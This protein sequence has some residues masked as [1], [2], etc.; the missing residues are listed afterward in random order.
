MIISRSSSA[1]SS[2]ISL[3]PAGSRRV[4]SLLRLCVCRS[5][6]QYAHSV[7]AGGVG[8]LREQ[9]LRVRPADN[10]GDAVRRQDRLDHRAAR[11]IGAVAGQLPIGIGGS[12]RQGPESVCRLIETGLGKR[13]MMRPTIC[14]NASKYGVSS[15]LPGL[16]IVTL[17]RSMSWMR[18]P[19]GVSSI[20]R[21]SWNSLSSLLCSTARRK[22][23]CACWNACSS[24][25]LASK[26]VL[27]GFGESEVSA[28]SPLPYRSFG[29]LAEGI[30][31]FT[32][33][34]DPAHRRLPIAATARPPISP[35]SPLWLPV[36]IVCGWK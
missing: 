9:M 12:G 18:R 23:A 15:A 30:G 22:S 32:V 13:T 5:D 24:R 2:L 8:L 25:C 17:S 26:F 33:G 16:N 11:R 10:I 20:S 34:D 29:P 28:A 31:I 6:Q 21:L 27:S 7:V 14:S 36:V 4:G 1:V 35:P 3:T 19:S